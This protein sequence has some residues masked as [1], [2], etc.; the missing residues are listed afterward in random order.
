MPAYITTVL[1]R[2]QNMNRLRKKSK[3]QLVSV[4]MMAVMVLSACGGGESKEETAPA[5]SPLASAEAAETAAPSPEVS[6]TASADAGEAV[7]IEI[8]QGSASENA[9]ED[10]GNPEVWIKG[11]GTLEADK[12]VLQGT[13]NL[14]PGVKVK[15]EI[16][17]AGYTMFGYDDTVEVNNDGSFTLE[18]K[19]PKDIKEGML[20]LTVSFDPAGQDANIEAY[21]ASGEK[22]T[23]PYIHQYED[24]DE[25][26]KKA[27]AFLHV[28]AASPAGTKVPLEVPTMNKPA[29]Y[30][31]PK[32]WIKP[33]VT[34]DGSYYQIKGTSNLLEGTEVEADVEIPDH[35]HY[36][37]KE[38]TT[39]GPDGSFQLRM[40][41]PKDIGEFY[42][43]LEVRPEEDDMPKA[44]KE[45][46]GLKGE[47]FTGDLVKTEQTDEGAVNYLQM[48]IK[49]GAGQK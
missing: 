19:R 24:D 38:D 47:H 18:M 29:D 21:G 34:A 4:L 8:V 42:L 27:L 11:D 48:K 12:L 5:P 22:L 28:D 14:A 37:Y 23:G 31:S 25:V 40:K 45:T 30:G 32:V 7:D 43:I 36:G 33:E 44:A 49:I 26:F 16:D 9:P 2:M 46:Y 15:G 10:Q 1:E 41:K 20:D 17:A 39:A 6:P 13:S 3:L 35:W